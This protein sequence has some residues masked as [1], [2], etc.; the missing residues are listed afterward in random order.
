M[1]ERTSATKAG[2]QVEQPPAVPV[3]QEPL[4]ELVLKNDYVIAL[5]V[6]IAPGQSTRLHTHSHDGAAIRL[7]E[8]TV[9]S[10]GPGRGPTAPQAVRPGDVSVAA[11]AKQP[12][13]HRVNN[14]GSTTFEVID[15]EFLNRPEGPA[16]APIT[17]PAAENDSARVYR[18]PL[19]PGES[20]PQHTHERPY[21]IVAATPMNLRMTAPDGASMEHP[22]KAGDVHWVDGK[23]THALAN[24]GAEPGV[25]VEV[26]LK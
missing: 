19:A 8:A 22:V 6:T 18:W 14:V 4:H 5:H 13:T 3:E 24:R 26:E 2:A 25:I 10:D 9:G 12:L 23:V 21:V 7:T 11:Y 1:T 20:T 15:L 16:A 17:P